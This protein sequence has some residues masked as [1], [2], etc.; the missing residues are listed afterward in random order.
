MSG[1]SL[2]KKYQLSNLFYVNS[3]YYKPIV[4]SIHQIKKNCSRTF[5]TPFIKLRLDNC[6]VIMYYQV[7]IYKKHRNDIILSQKSDEEYLIDYND[8]DNGDGTLKAI[9]INLRNQFEHGSS[10]H[11]WA[12]I[13]ANICRWF[14]N[15]TKQKIE[16]QTCCIKLFVG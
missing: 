11:K 2:K 1:Q 14:A 9:K 12:V 6:M 13:R 8:D 3:Y 10:I 5:G 7:T 15:L 16:S 4:K